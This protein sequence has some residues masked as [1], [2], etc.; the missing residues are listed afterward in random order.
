MRRRMCS[1]HTMS[2]KV[3]LTKDEQEERNPQGLLRLLDTQ[4]QEKFGRH[5]AMPSW[6]RASELLDHHPWHKANH[7]IHL[8]K[9]LH[10][11]HDDLVQCS[12]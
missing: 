3:R 1:C 9:L 11:L 6:S 2:A 7:T 12:V 10:V 5:P 8:Y 4:T